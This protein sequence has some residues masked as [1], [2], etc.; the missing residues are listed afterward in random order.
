M[1]KRC[2]RVLWTCAY[3]FWLMKYRLVREEKAKWERWAVYTQAWWNVNVAFNI[4]WWQQLIKFIPINIR[5][6]GWCA[7]GVKMWHFN[8]ICVLSR[9]VFHM[10]T[11]FLR[12][13][14][15]AV[16]PTPHTEMHNNVSN[17][18]SN[19]F[20]ASECFTLLCLT[21]SR[22]SVMRK[23]FHIVRKQKK[24][25]THNNKRQKRPH[26]NENKMKTIFRLWTLNIY[27][28]TAFLWCFQCCEYYSNCYC[29]TAARAIIK[30][31]VFSRHLVQ[32]FCEHDS[33]V[34]IK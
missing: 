25:H 27:F 9:C 23:L 30:Y 33:N 14:K 29:S 3:L 17:S 11:A 31:D 13:N 21:R 6:R 24:K 32:A 28:M 8:F 1:C 5:S 20:N 12:M 10:P 18:A 34:F 19:C 26:R 2:L 7:F 4:I 16:R 22:A 15:Q